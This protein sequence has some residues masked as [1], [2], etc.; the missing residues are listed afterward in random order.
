MHGTGDARSASRRDRMGHLTVKASAAPV[1]RWTSPA[2]IALRLALPLPHAADP[3]QHT[4]RLGRG[5]GATE[6]D[7][8]GRLALRGYGSPLP[9]GAAAPQKRGPPLLACTAHHSS[10]FV[11]RPGC[12]ALPPLAVFVVDDTSCAASICDRPEQGRLRRA[13]ARP[14]SSSSALCCPGQLRR[15]ASRGILHATAPILRQPAPTDAQTR[16]RHGRDDR[17][18]PGSVSPSLSFAT[19]LLARCS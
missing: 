7:R 1:T 2:P 3:R 6:G 8:Q 9:T 5:R 15:Q 18:D 17:D 10:N 13:G 16:Q 4:R 12:L 11:H 19:L 14:S